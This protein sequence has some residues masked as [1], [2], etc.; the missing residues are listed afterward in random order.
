MLNSGNPEHKDNMNG[1]VTFKIQGTELVGV[2][3]NHNK[4]Y[5]KFNR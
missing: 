4:I 1:N 5:N 3:K 2:L